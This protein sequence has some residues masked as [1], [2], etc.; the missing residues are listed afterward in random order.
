MG[1][2]VVT[3]PY[4]TPSQQFALLLAV[5]IDHFGDSANHSNVAL[6]KFNLTQQ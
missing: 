3:T 2:M 1:C 5:K 4:T 6:K